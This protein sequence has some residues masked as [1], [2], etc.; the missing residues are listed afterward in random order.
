VFINA[1]VYQTSDTGLYANG[2]SI[3]GPFPW[4]TTF[5]DY[6]PYMVFTNMFAI[7][8]LE[9]ICMTKKTA[10]KQDDDKYMGHIINVFVTTFY[11][12]IFLILIIL[13]VSYYNSKDVNDHVAGIG[14]VSYIDAASSFS[15]AY[16]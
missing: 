7:F 4:V 15:T 12:L 11:V 16:V 3:Y 8:Y 2:T 10:K 14:S 5:L 6:M 13:S 1:T 9:T